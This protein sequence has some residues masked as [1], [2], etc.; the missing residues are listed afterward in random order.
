VSEAGITVRGSGNTL[1]SIAREVGDPALFRLEGKTALCAAPFTLQGELAMGPGEVLR[2]ENPQREWARRFVYLLG[3][4]QFRD[5]A[6]EGA[7]WV[8]LGPSA[9]GTWRDV[10]IL[11]GDNGDSGYPLVYFR[12]SKLDWQ[13]GLIDAHPAPGI[14]TKFALGTRGGYYRG[15]VRNTLRGLRIRSYE[16]ALY[17]GSDGHHVDLTFDRCVFVTRSEAERAI[18]A[19]HATLADLGSSRIRLLHCTRRVGE[20]EA[21]LDGIEVTGSSG[22]VEIDDGSPETR[23]A[24][25]LL[26]VC[27][28]GAGD[29]LPVLERRL[30]RARLTRLAENPRLAGSLHE[31]RVQVEYLEK[32]RAALQKADAYHA[33]DRETIERALA[34]VE[35]TVAAGP[36]TLK[37]GTPYRPRPTPFPPGATGNARVEALG[38]GSIRVTTAGST[39]VYDPNASG[40]GYAAFTSESRIRGRRPMAAYV[41]WGGPSPRHLTPS[42]SAR[43]SW[44]LPWKTQIVQA[45]GP[46]VGFTSTVSGP[47]H[48]SRVSFIAFQELPEV[49]LYHVES[50]QSEKPVVAPRARFAAYANAGERLYNGMRFWNDDPEGFVAYGDAG[51]ERL[52]RSDA[53]DGVFVTSRGNR[54]YRPNLTRGVLVAQQ[55]GA[56]DWRR[57]PPCGWIVR[58]RDC[59]AVYTNLGGYYAHVVELHDP[60]RTDPEELAYD[61]LWFDGAGLGCWENLFALDA[62]FNEPCRPAPLVLRPGKP[63]AVDLVEPTGRARPVEIVVLPRAFSTL[64]TERPIYRG[65]AAVLLLRDVS[66]HSRIRL[67]TL[68]VRLRQCEPGRFTLASELSAP[69]RHVEFHLPTSGVAPRV[70]RYGNT[71]VAKWSRTGDEVVFVATV[72]PGETE[73][74]LEP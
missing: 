57:N 34:D 15:D 62:A 35:E 18:L 29:L 7:Y 27:G 40:R 58:R 16:H 70:V 6:I 31:A 19:T 37:P 38:G 59:E 8:D 54:W 39:L 43:M 25:G 41:P 11:S 51:S 68:P 46:I 12:T 61:L 56:N 26:P 23:R 30:R 69:L 53:L 55:N 65:D 5:C 72:A 48:G 1:V 13:G 9:S 42:E 47:R 24:P 20:R 28:P 17:D 50:L 49:L 71:T 22:C 73:V 4:M 21:P 44:E 3:A 36:A 63:L 66:P 45:E 2:M 10:R 60:K 67:G 52:F 14:F 64:E 32:V 33:R 74:V